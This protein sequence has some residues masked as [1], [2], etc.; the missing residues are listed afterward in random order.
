MIPIISEIYDL[1]W[2]CY[3]PGGYLKPWCPVNK[4]CA[5]R[6]RILMHFAR[7]HRRCHSAISDCAVHLTHSLQVS[8]P[9]KITEKMQF[10]TPK[11]GR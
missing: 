5:R 9:R 8:T 10:F 11:T 4:S 1:T 6:S 2:R 7:M 3:N